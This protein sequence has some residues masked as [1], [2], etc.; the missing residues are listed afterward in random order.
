MYWQVYLHK[1]VLCAEKMLINIIRRAREIN[2]GGAS[3]ALSIFLSADF[4]EEKIQE[5]LDDF[6]RMDDYDVLSAIKR[7]TSHSDKILSYLCKGIINR[8]LLKVKYSGSPFDPETLRAKKEIVKKYFNTNDT[9]ASYLV[10]TGEA[11][12]ETYNKNDE[13]IKILYKDGSVSDI[14]EVDN[15]LINQTLFGT[16]KKFYICFPKEELS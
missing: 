2:A 1:T 4:S 16:I 8:K 9:E 7:W 15:A 5:H 11:T 13:R 12:N 14:S 3:E 6:C 10:F